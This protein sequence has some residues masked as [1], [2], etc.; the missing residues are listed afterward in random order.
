MGLIDRLKEQNTGVL[1]VLAVV[2]AVV[3]LVVLVVLTVIL[4]A[5]LGTFVLN[6]GGSVQ[7]NVQAGASVASDA[8]ADE[9]EVVWTSNQN[10][11]YLT[12]EW[13]ATGGGVRPTATSG[14]ATVGDGSVRLS[15]VGSAVTLGATDPGTE[16]TVQVTVTAVAVDG[17]TP[18]TT[19]VVVREVT[20]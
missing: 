10:A 20:I 2:A 13:E 15:S 17:Q 16:T 12:V 8:D 11:D 9:I 19:V 14:D 6:L 5:V 3:G 1:V 18:S 4:A 7:E